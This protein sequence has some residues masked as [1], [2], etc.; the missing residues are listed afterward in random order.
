MNVRIAHD[1]LVEQVLG[2]RIYEVALVGESGWHATGN[3]GKDFSLAEDRFAGEA[4]ADIRINRMGNVGAGTVRPESHSGDV[5]LRFGQFGSSETGGVAQFGDA[6]NFRQLVAHVRG[7]GD[8]VVFR[9]QRGR[10]QHQVA[11]CGLAPRIAVAV[12]EREQ[13]RADAAVHGF[14]A[15]KDTLPGNKAVV[16]DGVGVGRARDKSTLQMLACAQVVNSDDL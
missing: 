11:E 3:V 5:D 13:Q 15:E 1:V 4:A 14:A 16:K 12:E 10:A 6:D 9:S 2:L 7:L 8:A